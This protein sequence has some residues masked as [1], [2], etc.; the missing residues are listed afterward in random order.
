[1]LLTREPGG[2]EIGQKLRRILLDRRSKISPVAELCLYEASRAIL[3]MEV[4]RPALRSGW[5]VIVDRFQ[6]STWAY[7]GWAGGT[8]LKLV[9][10]LGEAAMRGILPDLTLLLDLPV[11]AGLSRARHPNRMEAKPV[12]FHEKVRQGFLKLAS[13]EP[14]RFRLIRADRPREQVQAEMRTAVAELLRKRGGR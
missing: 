5:I 4:I 6:D 12:A 3:V 9:E 1:M 11:R 10:N 7:Q 13:R 8:D 14:K 2:T